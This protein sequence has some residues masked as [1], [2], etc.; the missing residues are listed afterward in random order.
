MTFKGQTVTIFTVKKYW[1]LLLGFQDRQRSD[2]ASHESDEPSARGA[3]D[4]GAFKI[5]V[6]MNLD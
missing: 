6:V 5:I 1:L 3:P 4:K 2:K